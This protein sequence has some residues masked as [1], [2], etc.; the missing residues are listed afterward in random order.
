[1]NQY[2]NDSLFAAVESGDVAKVKE[3]LSAEGKVIA[4]SFYGHKSIICAAKQGNNEI[5][6]ILLESNETADRKSFWSNNYHTASV[7][8]RH[9]TCNGNM[10]A[11]KLLLEYGAGA[12]V[13]NLKEAVMSAAENGCFEILKML[14]ESNPKTKWKRFWKNISVVLRYASRKGN[15]EMVKLLI[16]YGAISVHKD[17]TGAIDL[18]GA[19]IEALFIGNPDLILLLLKAGADVNIHDDNGFTPLIYA[20]LFPN[21]NMELIIEAMLAAGADV[22]AKDKNRCSALM[23][24]E[25]AGYTKIVEMMR[26]VEK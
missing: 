3:L 22:N 5:L 11:V 12:E 17:S 21:E 2:I 18:T 9:A 1:M 7:A 20:V 8:L 10:E 19:L 24:A 23:Y 13:N 15:A 14:L 6:K 26:N 16:E 4:S 25:K